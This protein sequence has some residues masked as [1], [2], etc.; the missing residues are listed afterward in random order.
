MRIK[1]LEEVCVCSVVT[2]GTGI[3]LLSSGNVFTLS[4]SCCR[5]DRAQCIFPSGGVKLENF[6]SMVVVCGEIIYFLQNIKL[7]FSDIM[8]LHNQILVV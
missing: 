1:V 5:S 8:G 7:L 6:L 3:S 2:V 4:Q